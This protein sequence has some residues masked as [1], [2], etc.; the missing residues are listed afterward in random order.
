MSA[1]AFGLGVGTRNED[2]KWL[3]VF[4]PAPVLAPSAALTAAA[5][6]F[7]TQQPLDDRQL[8]QLRLDP[9]LSHHSV[10]LERHGGN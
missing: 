6:K 2:D 8:R 4:F 9:G 3:E 5:G 7:D 10:S 1:F